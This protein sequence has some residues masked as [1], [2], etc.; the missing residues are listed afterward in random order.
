MNNDKKKWH[1]LHVENFPNTPNEKKE[2]NSRFYYSN[3][4][5]KMKNIHTVDFRGSLGSPSQND[6][7]SP[8]SIF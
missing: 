2:S 5:I 1:V 4:R 8:F 3:I 7:A 6:T